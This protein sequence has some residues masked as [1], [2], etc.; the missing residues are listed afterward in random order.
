[1]KILMVCLGNICR[2]PL[3][4]GILESKVRGRQLNWEVDSAGT[5]TWHI[6]ERPDRRSVEVARQNGIDITRQLARQVKPSD[7][8][9]FDLILAMDSSNYTDL[10]RMAPDSGLTSKVQLILNYSFKDRNM[11]VP[12]PYFDGRFQHVFD[13]LDQ[14]C[15]DLIESQIG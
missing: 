1:M 7:F 4:Q 15:D 5:S 3:A 6:G 8:H 12:D 11:A 2:S 13:L 10:V 9:D 14:A